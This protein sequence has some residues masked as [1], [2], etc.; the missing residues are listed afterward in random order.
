[1]WT[2]ATEILQCY[3][4]VY[5]LLLFKGSDH[6]PINQMYWS[7]KKPSVRGSR[8]GELSTAT[9]YAGRHSVMVTWPAFNCRGCGFELRQRLFKNMFMCPLNILNHWEIS[10]TCEEELIKKNLW[11]RGCEQES[12]QQWRSRNGH[13]VVQLSCAAQ[14]SRNETVCT[15]QSCLLFISNYK[16]EQPPRYQTA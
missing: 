8:R 14:H 7:T 1:M 4:A 12:H 3:R 16:R 10:R 5:W 6:R 2:S 13:P 9:G 11:A 15:V